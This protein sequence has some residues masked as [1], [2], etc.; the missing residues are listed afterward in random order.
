[1]RGMTLRLHQIY[2]QHTRAI[3]ISDKSRIISLAELIFLIEEKRGRLSSGTS[4]A[5]Y[6]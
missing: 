5:I 3:V 1:M 4:G 2:T 6:S